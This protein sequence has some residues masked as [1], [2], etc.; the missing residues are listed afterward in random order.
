[1]NKDSW[2]ERQEGHCT[3]AP[4]HTSSRERPGAEFGQ[5]SKGLP[6]GD[7]TRLGRGSLS[8]SAKVSVDLQPPPSTQGSAH[9]LAGAIRTVSHSPALHARLLWVWEVCAFVVDRHSP[10][11]T[12]LGMEEE[13]TPARSYPV[14]LALASQ[15]QLHWPPKASGTS[16]H[17]AL[18]PC[19]CLPGTPSCQTYFRVTRARVQ[20][21]PPAGHTWDG[22]QGMSG[23]PSAGA[24]R[25]QS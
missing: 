13:G 3:A 19:T 4:A 18:P 1:M 22:R 8:A 15:S 11:A 9:R 25:G 5:E 12:S 20:A 6:R 23:A 7:H 24:K 17:P 14:P 16:L 21:W 2:G 10:K